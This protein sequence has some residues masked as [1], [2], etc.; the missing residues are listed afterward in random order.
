MNEDEVK[1]KLKQVAGKAQDA[2]G[3]VTGN[4]DDDVA[5][6]AKEAE[7]KVQEGYGKAKEAV[8]DALK[9]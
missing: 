7:G 1:G 6:K 9:K 8:Q 5:G 2:R 4:A 3:D